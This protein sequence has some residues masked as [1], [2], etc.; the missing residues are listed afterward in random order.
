M[1]PFENIIR[2]IGLNKKKKIHAR[3]RIDGIKQPRPG[4]QEHADHHSSTKGKRE[5]T[6]L[7]TSSILKEKKRST[8]GAAIN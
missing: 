3:K 6:V 2:C 1:I 5:W 7:R 8:Q 4:D